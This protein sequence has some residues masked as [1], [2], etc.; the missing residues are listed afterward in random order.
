MTTQPA[1]HVDLAETRARAGSLLEQGA[2][3]TALEAGSL[4]AGRSGDLDE[5]PAVERFDVVVIGGGQAGLST[6]YHLARKGLSFVILEEA[7]RIGDVWRK[8]W[9]SLRFFTAARF[10]GLDGMRF[11]ARSTHLPTKDE[12]ADFLESYARKFELPVRTGMK[13]ETVTRQGGKYL[14]VAGGRRFE[15]RHVVLAA[16]GHQR[17]EMPSF[18]AGLDPKIRQIHSSAYKNPAQLNAGTVLLVGAGNSGAE[19]AMDLRRSHKVWLAGKIPGEIPF[20]TD[21]SFAISVLCPI[22]FRGIFHRLLSVDTPI[23]RKVKPNFEAHGGPLI[24]TKARDLDKA[25]V[26]RVPRVAGVRDGKPV[27]EDGRVLDVEN[28]VWCTGYAQGIDWVRLPS[29]GA[30]GVPR[31]YRGVVEGEP[32]LYVVGLFYQHSPSSAMIHGVGRDARR[33]AEKVAERMAVSAR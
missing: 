31:Q 24:R 30:G 28:V 3:F 23:G 26:M 25:G 8:R 11:P 5:R 14:I 21:T 10:C 22:I 1:T 33:V 18:A 27:L 16:A 29:F 4:R 6:G 17:P 20:K 13:V 15:A 12:F 32:G 9:D 7:D 19:I 2:A